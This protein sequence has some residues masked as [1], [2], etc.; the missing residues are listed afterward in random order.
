MSLLS[1]FVVDDEQLVAET[2]ALILQNNGFT[3]R[4]F[5]EPLK[6]IAAARLET[7]ELVL[8]DVMMPLLSG[9]EFAIALQYEC[10]GCKVLLFSGHAEALDLVSDAREEGH[11]FT[12]LAKPLHPAD[13]VRR[14]RT[15]HLTGQ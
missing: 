8:S 15:Q 3:A 1:I 12:L 7:P 11:E 9:V 5:S 10:P 13:L 14:I 4:F 6:A 2:L